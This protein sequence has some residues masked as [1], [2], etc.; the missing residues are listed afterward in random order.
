MRRDP[1]VSPLRIANSRERHFDAEFVVEPQLFGINFSRP[2]HAL[3][4]FGQWNRRNAAE[5]VFR[6]GRRDF[7]P[8]A[9]PPPRAY[10][11]FMV[12]RSQLAPVARQQSP[13][14]TDRFGDTKP[15]RRVNRARPVKA[16]L[17]R[18]VLGPRTVVAVADDGGL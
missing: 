13:K 11:E 1:K 3:K 17:K 18:V 4:S 9:Q 14:P 7:Q 16:I 8:F 6:A 10:G 2:R 15:R 12:A 5:H